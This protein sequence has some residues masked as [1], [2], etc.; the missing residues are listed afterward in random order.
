M[1]PTLSERVTNQDVQFV[2]KFST[3]FNIYISDLTP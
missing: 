2:P 3:T 1:N